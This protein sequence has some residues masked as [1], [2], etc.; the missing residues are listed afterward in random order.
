MP[1]QDVL[2]LAIKQPP[3]AHS[4][5]LVT[6]IVVLSDISNI[7]DMLQQFPHA[8]GLHVLRSTCHH[9]LCISSQ[10]CS[11]KCAQKLAKGS[12]MLAGTLRKPQAADPAHLHTAPLAGCTWLVPCYVYQA[13]GRKTGCST[14][15]CTNGGN[16]LP[17]SCHLQVCL[18]AFH[19]RLANRSSSR[20]RLPCLRSNQTGW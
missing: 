17:S 18:R 13:P 7:S 20:G 6:Q 12:L 8:P 19:T 4:S 15:L 9:T 2:P 3:S 11:K 1:L 14:V 10:R 16:S 5:L